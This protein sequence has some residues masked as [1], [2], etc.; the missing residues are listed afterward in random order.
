MATLEFNKTGT[1]SGG[2]SLTF[3]TQNFSVVNMA[4][5]QLT[6][7]SQNFD[8]SFD[9]PTQTPTITLTPT[10]SPTPTVTP[11]NTPTSTLT[12]TP[13]ETP[14]PTPTQTETPS[15][16]PTPTPVINQPATLSLFPNGEFKITKESQVDL[17]LLISS[18]IIGVDAVINY[19]P[20]AVDII[21]VSSSGLFSGN[22]IFNNSSPGILRISA[23]Q[24]PQQS[25]NS[26]GIVASITVK[27][28]I[29]GLTELNFNFTLGDKSESNVIATN[30]EDILQTTNGAILDI[31]GLDV[32]AYLNLKTPSENLA[33]GHVASG[34][35]EIVDDTWLQNFTTDNDGNSQTWQLDYTYLNSEL[36]FRLKSSGFLRRRISQTLLEGTNVLNFG[37]L[38]AGDLNDDGIVNNIDV[39]I[40]Y[41][42]WFLTGPSDYNKDGIVNSYDFWIL[43]NNFFREDE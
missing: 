2:T 42:N 33:I 1:P 6:V 43:V 26:G 40:M 31:L 4:A 9:V 32:F 15:P 23:T 27:P 18:P 34:S 41:Q 8:I 38:V 13:S 19:D 16:S 10:E 21:N 22:F 12:P 11:T 7:G 28:K 36:F 5:Q 39:A 3:N 29:I 14:T 25:I 37:N 17:S 30:G 20:L 24:T 35:V